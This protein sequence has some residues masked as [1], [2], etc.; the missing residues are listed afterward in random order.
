MKTVLHQREHYIFEHHPT[1]MVWPTV[2]RNLGI[3]GK[4]TGEFSV[5]RWEPP[6]LKVPNAALP[7][8]HPKKTVAPEQAWGKLLQEGAGK[9][10]ELPFTRPTHPLVE[11]G[12]CS[13]VSPAVPSK[14]KR[15][16]E[17]LLAVIIAAKLDPLLISSVLRGVSLDSLV[18]PVSESRFLAL[19]ICIILTFWNILI[20]LGGFRAGAEVPSG[21]S[22][23]S[24]KEKAGSVTLTTALA[25]P[26]PSLGLPPRLVFEI[27][28]RIWTDDE[29]S[30]VEHR[31]GHKEALG[32]WDMVVLGNGCQAATWSVTHMVRRALQS[33]AF[34]KAQTS[35]Y[36][37][38]Q[39]LEDVSG[40]VTPK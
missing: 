27:P 39:R 30:S 22:R 7:P 8:F 15:R 38:R 18:S 24:G 31:T 6:Y 32:C 33:A 13:T 26:P 9:W 4:S 1:G 16:R 34:L 21:L 37:R 40:C 11:V 28:P 5:H 36:T 25:A 10:L 23:L 2:H 35:A 12:T 14:L 20:K 19:N 3:F 29:G 17:V